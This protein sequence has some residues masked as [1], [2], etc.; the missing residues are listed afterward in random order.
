MAHVSITLL[1]YVKMKGM[2]S[3][4]RNGKT[5]GTHHKAEYGRKMKKNKQVTDVRNQIVI[6][7]GKVTVNKDHKM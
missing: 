6:A 7:K 5:L 1:P 3:I 4:K 2:K